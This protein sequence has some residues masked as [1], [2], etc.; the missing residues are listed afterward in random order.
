MKQER[1]AIRFMAMVACLPAL[2]IGAEVQQVELNPFSQEGRPERIEVR[3]GRPAEGPLFMEVYEFHTIMRPE[4]APLEDTW[5]HAR[6]MEH[7][8]QVEAGQRPAYRANSRDPK[9]QTILQTVEPRIYPMQSI[10]ETTFATSWVASHGRIY[11][12]FKIGERALAPVY[13][14]RVHCRHADMRNVEGLKQALQ[15]LEL[16]LRRQ[17]AEM[18]STIF[19][20]ANKLYRTGHGLRYMMTHHEEDPSRL[21]GL[22]QELNDNLAAARWQD[23]HESLEQFGDQVRRSQRLFRQ[24]EVRREGPSVRLALTDRTGFAYAEDPETEVYVRQAGWR[25]ISPHPPAESSA[26]H[27]HHPRSG[28]DRRQLTAGAVRL[29]ASG[30]VVMGTIPE[31]W[32]HF[33]VV[34]LYGD[35]RRYFWTETFP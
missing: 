24:A 22:I 4:L 18:A 9:V 33:E 13:S 23:A 6:Q 5:T 34:V 32:E 29:R 2:L 3:L 25:P 30:E 10:D 15:R 20:M 28:P 35:G 26:Q 1:I 11:F 16:P 7:M 8:R 27:S 12:R 14:M 17:H 21:D 31:K 19:G